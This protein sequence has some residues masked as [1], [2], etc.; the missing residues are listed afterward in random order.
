M[1]VR[2]RGEEESSFVNDAAS[3]RRPELQWID[4]WA[5]LHI[6]KATS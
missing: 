4:G 2:Q 1:S 3:E 6:Q 5:S